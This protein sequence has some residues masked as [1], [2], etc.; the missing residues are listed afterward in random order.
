M[1]CWGI[2]GCWE[3]YGALACRLWDHWKGS[4]RDGHGK[5]LTKGK[6]KA[7]PKWWRWLSTIVFGLKKE[8]GIGGN[9]CLFSAY[10]T[11]FNYKNAI[12]L[13]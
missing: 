12:V 10:K 5:G 3:I 11:K 1:E 7:K 6:F 4:G 9:Q 2:N 13:F 8:D